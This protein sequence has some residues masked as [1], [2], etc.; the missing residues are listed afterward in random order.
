VFPEDQLGAANQLRFRLGPDMS[1]GLE[2][3]VKRHG[4]EMVGEASELAFLRQS[5]DDDEMSAYERLLSEALEGDPTLFAREDGVEAAW[6][7]VDPVV[8]E[9]TPALPYEP[10]SWGPEQ[11]DALAPRPDG[12][13]T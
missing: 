4:D 11:A 6:R 8:G 3:R 5:A 1:I 7:I 2:A 12:D 9:H 13:V 10:G